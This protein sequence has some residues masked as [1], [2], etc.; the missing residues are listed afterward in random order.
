[1]GSRPSPLLDNHYVPAKP[2]FADATTNRRAD[3]TD[4]DNLADNSGNLE[5]SAQAR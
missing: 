3:I 5:P 2:D 4:R 1:M